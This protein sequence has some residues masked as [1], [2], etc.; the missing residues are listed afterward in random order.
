MRPAPLTVIKGGINRQRTKGG[1]RADNLYDL[2]NGFVTDAGT[3]VVR[4]GTDRQTVLD[5]QT[6]GLAAFDGSRHTFCH[7]EVTVPDGY[8]LHIL[9]HPD[10]IVG[11]EI[12]LEKIHFA[13]PFMGALYVVAEFEDGAIYHYWLQQPDVWASDTIYRAGQ[14]IFPTVPNGLAYQASRLG[15]PY[16]AWAPNVP[17]S[18]GTGS[19][20]QS[21]IEPTVYNDY[22]Y[23]C[24]E[25]QG[26]NPISGTV[27]PTW[28]VE[29]GAQVVE[30]TDPG[31][32]TPAPPAPPSTQ[33]P[34]ETIQ[35]RYGIYDAARHAVNR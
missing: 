26:L 24:V 10:S 22:F 4:P 16:P 31:Q 23:V 14:L 34:D 18:D 30:E 12:A 29:D 25:T 13:S 7:G 32:I 11:Y 8:T 33:T 9:V 2:L 28:P 17:R 15:A 3:V 1:A 35:E 6:R 5:E 19:Y 21:I 27:E 20:E